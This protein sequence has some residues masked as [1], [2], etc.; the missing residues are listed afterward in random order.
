MVQF[1]LLPDVKLEYVRARRTKRI[2]M[3]FAVLA[4]VVAL[5]IFVGLLLLVDV[6]QKKNLSDLDRDI[7]SSSSK[8]T[9]TPDLNQILTVQNQLNSLPSLDAQ[10]PAT[11]RLFD[12]VEKVTPSNVFINKL[13]I[14]YSQH[15]IAITGTADAIDTVN[16]FVDTLK[17]TTYTATSS[18]GQKT[19]AVNAFSSV[20]LTN[21]GRD[22][23]GANYTINLNFDPIIF[24]NTYTDVALTVPDKISTRS[25]VDQ[26]KPLFQAAPSVN[27]QGQ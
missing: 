3:V 27:N 26:P 15:T 17:F 24:D 18:N 16:T 12:Y 7:N 23:Q 1:N 25:V 20:V 13:D 2:V 19:E 9:R 22:N 11:T 10:K 6:A 21:F 14:D 4:S 8:L 5:V